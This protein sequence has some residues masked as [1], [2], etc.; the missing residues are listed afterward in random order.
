MIIVFDKNIPEKK[1]E[2][3]H[4]CPT[5]GRLSQLCDRWGSNPQHR[6][7]WNRSNRFLRFGDISIM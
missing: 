3:E 4:T 1:A 6:D 2:T 5:I 7:P